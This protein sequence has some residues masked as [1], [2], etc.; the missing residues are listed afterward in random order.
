MMAIEGF[1]PDFGRTRA[2]DSRLP[3]TRAEDP[4]RPNR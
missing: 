3:K 2:K 1:D 4:R